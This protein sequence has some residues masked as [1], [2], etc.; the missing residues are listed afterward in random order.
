MTVVMIL[1]LSACGQTEEI[2]Q[3]TVAE[4]SQAVSTSSIA[5]ST[6]A[7][8]SEKSKEEHVS[9]TTNKD[10]LYSVVEYF[11][12]KGITIGDKSDKIFALIGAKGGYSIQLNGE[13]V[14]LYEYD[15]DSKAELTIA[16]LKTAKDGYIDMVGTKIN[17]TLNG[18]IVLANYDNHPD[19]DKI[20]ELFKNFK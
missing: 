4:Q 2:S 12:T 18:N 11:K 1:A 10:V 20:V 5:P 16:S 6:E 17:V 14:E 7:Q 8:V 19:K 9:D 13:E 3:S 15:P